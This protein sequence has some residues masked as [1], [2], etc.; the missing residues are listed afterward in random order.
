M[1]IVDKKRWQMKVRVIAEGNQPRNQTRT[2]QAMQCVED[3]LGWMCCTIW[4]INI[5]N[6]I[7]SILK[8]KLPYTV[9]RHQG[10]T[11]VIIIIDSIIKIITIFINIL[12]IIIIYK[13]MMTI[14]RW[15]SYGG[16]SDSYMLRSYF[17][18]MPLWWC[19]GVDRRV[20][21]WAREWRPIL[22]QVLRSSAHSCLQKCLASLSRWWWSC[23]AWFSI[24]FCT[25]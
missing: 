2:E 20:W 23:L 12:S 14:S 9:H 1:R 3:P 8:I 17:G 21:W 5:S 11:R 13:M 15:F 6:C 19:T 10:Y 7:F 18:C 4:T 16:F 24:F 25:F 22:D